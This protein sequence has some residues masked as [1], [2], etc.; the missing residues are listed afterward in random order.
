[1]KFSG[2]GFALLCTSA[3]LA[4]CS[5]TPLDPQP[6]NTAAVAAAAPASSSASGSSS[7]PTP[8]AA[9]TVTAVNLLPHLDPKSP[10][11]TQRSIYFDFDVFTVKSDY[12]DLIS[13]HGKYLASRPALTI[14]IEGNSDERGSTEYNLA[15]GQKRAQ[16][17]LQALKIYGVRDSQMEAVSWGKERPK[18]EGHDE[19]AWAANRRVDLVY[20]KP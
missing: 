10:I 20:P 15:L 16:A 1:M 8:V 17:V 19:T 4:G 2:F 18:A 9:S 14:R 11:S 6:A 5:S 7:T 13:R 12:S 3:L